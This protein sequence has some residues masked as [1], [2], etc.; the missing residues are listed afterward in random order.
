MTFYE[1]EKTLQEEVD[2]RCPRSRADCRE[3]FLLARGA[4]QSPMG[5]SSAKG[6]EEGA[7]GSMLG[8]KSPGSRET[9][10]KGFDTSLASGQSRG[11]SGGAVCNE[12]RMEFLA[13]L[14]CFGS[15][16]ARFD[17]RSF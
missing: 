15:E 1:L 2:H 7:L 11:V 12:D 9:G 16:W 10:G 6:R 3:T 8:G 17:S 13:E 5:G 14:S 4:L